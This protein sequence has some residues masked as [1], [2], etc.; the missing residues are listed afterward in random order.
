[1]IILRAIIKELINQLYKKATLNHIHKHQIKKLD[2]SNILILDNHLI[3][4]SDNLKIHP[5]YKTIKNKNNAF[6]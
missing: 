6:R 5:Q 1:M 2:K 4:K 3:K